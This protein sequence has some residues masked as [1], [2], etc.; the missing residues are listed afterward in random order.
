MIMA[1]KDRG[2]CPHPEFIRKGIAGITKQ[3]ATDFHLPPDTVESH[4]ERW[5]CTPALPLIT[6][7]NKYWQLILGLFCYGYFA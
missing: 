2:L 3:T 7:C 1:K 6:S 4:D 5:G